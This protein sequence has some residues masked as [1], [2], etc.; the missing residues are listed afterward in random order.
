MQSSPQSPVCVESLFTRVQT[1]AVYSTAR[2]TKR[3]AESDGEKLNCTDLG[4]RRLCYESTGCESE[5]A[6]FDKIEFGI[7]N[8]GMYSEKQQRNRTSETR[9]HLLVDNATEQNS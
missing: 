1:A 6:E 7:R 8:P 2:L 4:S 9:Q 5:S 3:Q